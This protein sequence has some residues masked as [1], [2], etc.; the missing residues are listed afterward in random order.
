MLRRVTLL[1]AVVAIMTVAVA[2]A[3]WAVVRT[4]TNGPDTFVGTL[5]SDEL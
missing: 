4:G 2:G 3:A 5:G 1:A